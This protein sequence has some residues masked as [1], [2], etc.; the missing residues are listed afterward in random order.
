MTHSEALQASG[1]AF[2]FTLKTCNT[3]LPSGVV[4]IG[5]DY[6]QAQVAGISAALLFADQILLK[7]ENVGVAV[8]YCRGIAIL[9]HPFNDGS[10]A[11]RATGMKQ[12]LFH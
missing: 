12:N 4:I 1:S 2:G 5:I 11:W 10:A 3:A 6:L 8:V 7:G 9:H